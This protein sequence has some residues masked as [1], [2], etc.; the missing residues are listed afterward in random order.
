IGLRRRPAL[1][2][3]HFFRDVQTEHAVGAVFTGPA[4]EPA[5]TAAEVYGLQA[6]Y[7]RQ[8]CFERRPFGR[9]VETAD[10]ARHLAVA[11]EK[12]R[13]VVDVLSHVWIALLRSFTGGT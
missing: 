2:L 10:G 5:V 3:Q 1:L 13:V 6:F 11:L 9:C 7:G 4:A 12:L 8:H